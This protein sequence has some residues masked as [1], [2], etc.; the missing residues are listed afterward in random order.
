MDKVRVKIITKKR[1]NVHLYILCHSDKRFEEAKVA[2]ADYSWAFPI[3]MKYQ[4]CTFENAFWKQLLEIKEE[5]SKCKMVGTL[6]SIAYKKI[7]L[8]EIDRILHTPSAWSSSGYYN[9]MNADKPLTNDH[10]H[11]LKIIRDVCTSL[12]IQ[13]PK[14]AWCNY[15][16]CSPARMEKFIEWYH[17]RL[18]P[19]VL[20][21]P[22]AM[23]NSNYSGRL[24]KD[25]LITLCGTPYYPHVPFVIERLTKAFFS[26]A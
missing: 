15:W 19:T 21:H 4:N 14:S 17:G 9:F 1:Q 5:W 25:E 3:R 12:Q 23:T 6:S 11:L 10:P 13:V 8:S 22:L 2:F 24:T 18:Q 20:A 26:L 16:M 7:K